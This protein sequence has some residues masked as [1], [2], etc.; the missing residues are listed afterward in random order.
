M[1]QWCAWDGRAKVV[2]G[3]YEGKE[4]AA[5]ALLVA[6]EERHWLSRVTIG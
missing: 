4:W 1:P 5:K 6:I 2:E 3:R